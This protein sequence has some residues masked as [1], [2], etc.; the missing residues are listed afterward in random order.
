MKIENVII[1]DIVRKEDNGKHILIG[2]YPKNV[3]VGVFPAMLQFQVWFQTPVEEIKDFPVE[4][5]IIDSEKKPIAITTGIVTVGP[6]DIGLA[7]IIIPNVL[8]HVP[9]QTDMIFQIRE[10]KK[11]WSTL[12]TLPI[13]LQNSS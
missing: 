3:R 12:K 11:R 1:C 5:R 2:V 4:F 9:K 13:S 6:E 7:T 10:P 8:V